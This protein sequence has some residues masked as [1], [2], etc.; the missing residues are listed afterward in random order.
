MRIMRREG[1]FLFLETNMRCF[2]NGKFESRGDFI[3]V[4]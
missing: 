2:L 1:G 4:V 3:P